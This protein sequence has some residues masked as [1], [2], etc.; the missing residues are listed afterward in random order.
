MK[1]P[2]EETYAVGEKVLFPEKPKAP[3]VIRI[4]TYNVHG[5]KGMDARISPER[6]ARV[7]ARHQPDIVAL[8]ELDMNRL[9]SGAMDQPHII[10][11]ELE[12]F[13]HFH[14]SFKVEEE[15]YGNAILSRFPMKLICAKQLP[16]FNG[17]KNLEPRGALWVTLNINGM[18]LQIINT[19]L[20]LKRKERLIQIEDLLGFD[21]LKHPD[22]IDPL[23]LIG[24]FNALPNSMV[25]KRIKKSLRDV[26][27][28]MVNYSPKATWFGHLPLGRIDHIF[29][30][31]K[32]EI[33]NVEV[34]NTHFNRM[35]SDHL[36][37]IVDIKLT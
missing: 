27:E 1:K 29:V 21:W 14:P 16:G 8:Q 18:D 7:I 10:A 6:I 25:C 34:A 3:E 37:L 17:Q 30:S 12:M 22:C 13:Y 15:H 24:D 23:V 33:K 5:C 11:K 4:M 26:Q 36:P 35:S 2:S 19:H 31:K 20:G 9:R 32:V 28:E